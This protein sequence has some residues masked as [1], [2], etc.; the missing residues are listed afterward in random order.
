VNFT[1]V[2]TAELA[3]VDEAGTNVV[4]DVELAGA[5]VEVGAVEVGAIEGG[6]V[7]ATGAIVVV[8]P[9]DDEPPHP[10]NNVDAVSAPITSIRGTMEDPFLG[11]AVSRVHSWLVDRRFAWR[12]P[13]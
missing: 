8:V 9:D 7:V 12:M 13:S 3:G 1:G 6:A 2:P 4:A 10:I 5:A 11:R